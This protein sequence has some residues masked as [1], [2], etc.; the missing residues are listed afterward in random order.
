MPTRLLGHMSS[1]SFCHVKSPRCAT[2]NLPNVTMLPTDCAFSVGSTG[3]GVNDAQYR[4]AAPAPGSG[5]LIA[6]PPEVTMRQ[7]RPV[8][9]ILS[10]GLATVCFDAPKSVGYTLSRNA[11]D[12]GC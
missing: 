2:R 5:V 7:S 12:A 3:F 8:T 4:F 1:N 11:V 10:P 6:C 9:A